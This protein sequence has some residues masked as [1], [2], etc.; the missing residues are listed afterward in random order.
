MH[1][2]AALP[3][4][5]AEPRF[6]SVG[7]ETTTIATNAAAGGCSWAAECSAH[8][9]T[10][11]ARKKAMHSGRLAWAMPRMP[12]CSAA[13]PRRISMHSFTHPLATNMMR[14]LA[15]ADA[16]WQAALARRLQHA[17]V[18][19]LSQ[20]RCRQRGSTYTPSLVR[21]GSCH[22]P[23]PTM[24]PA[25]AGMPS[26]AARTGLAMRL[27]RGDNQ[28]DQSSGPW[29]ARQAPTRAPR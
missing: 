13:P 22:R 24:S 20:R 18:D 28:P 21:T 4:T 7:N 15:S 17:T 5:A 23:S 14:A 6:L 10:L 8:R 25:P 9:S 1:Q 19:A 27:Q 2:A 3:A 16:T 26:S 12:S 29:L 11:A